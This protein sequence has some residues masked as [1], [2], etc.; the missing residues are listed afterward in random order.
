MRE[1]ARY[2]Y[3][4][5]YAVILGDK[6]VLQNDAFIRSLKL[7]EVKF[8]PDT[9]RADYE[10]FADCDEMYPWELNPLAL[11]RFIPARMRAAETTG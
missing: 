2:I 1:F 9:M 5:V 4:H 8:D 7:R 10:K 3:A 6:R 11:E